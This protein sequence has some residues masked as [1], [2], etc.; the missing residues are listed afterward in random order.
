MAPVAGV[1]LS[2]L[3]LAVVICLSCMGCSAQGGDS[4]PQEIKGSDSI[5]SQKAHGTCPRPVMKP[6]RWKADYETADRIC[7][8]NRHYAEMSGSFRG[9]GFPAAVQ[10]ADAEGQTITFYDSVTG[11][12]LFIAPKGRSWKDF[13]KESLAHGWPS[14]RDE[15][16]VKENVRVLSD[17]ETVSVDGTHLGHNLPDSRGNRYCINLVSVAGRST[18]EL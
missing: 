14:F 11:K 4:A 10:A 3:C 1:R 18:I 5:M 9:T 8:F 7:C 6:L 16:V 12:P 13:E 17:G 2:L 15:E